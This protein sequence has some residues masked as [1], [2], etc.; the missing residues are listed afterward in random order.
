MR[1]DAVA[2]GLAVSLHDDPVAAAVAMADRF[3]L[4]EPELVRDE[5]LAVDAARREFTATLELESWAQASSAKS[6][7][8]QEFVAGFTSPEGGS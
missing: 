5:K 2:A 3:A 4:L 7:R 8:L 6:L 1:P